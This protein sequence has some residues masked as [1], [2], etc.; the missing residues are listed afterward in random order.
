M[1]EGRATAEG[2]ARFRARFAAAAQAGHFRRL[3][4]LEVSSIGLGTYLG[5]ATDEV[6]RAYEA[7]VLEALGRGCNVF[8]CAINYRHQRSERALGRALAEAFE[9]GLARRDEVVVCSKGGFLPFDGAAPPDAGLYLKERFFDTGLMASEDL[10]AGCHSLAGPFL[11]DQVATSRANLGLASID[12]YYLHNPETAL[13]EVDRAE[14]GRRLEGAFAA[15]REARDRG[16]IGVVGV[17]TWDGLRMSPGSRTSVQLSELLE[18][19]GAELGA[20]QAPANLA[21]PEL[22]AAPSQLVDEVVVPLVVAARHFGLA[23]VASAS[24]LQGG[25]EALPPDIA[26]AFP[27][28]STDAQRA[29]QF[30]RSLPG[31]TVALVGMSSVEHVREN[32]ALAEVPPASLE[33]SQGLVGSR[34]L[35]VDPHRHL[36]RSPAGAE[37][38][39]PARTL[40]PG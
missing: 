36:D 24:I 30:T 6:D 34:D 18:T 5:D 35:W 33:A 32:L 38:R 25:L 28:L 2:T 15:L 22:L 37:W 19:A 31:V 1:I 13:R 23:L 27:G 16:E 40:K 4:D 7:A 8:D 29:L 11:R 9:S 20:V 10:V 26:A 21:M 39:D 14:V 12:V 3:G 17:A